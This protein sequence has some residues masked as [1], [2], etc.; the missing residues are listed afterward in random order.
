MHTDQT[1]LFDIEVLYAAEILFE[2][3]K[4][5]KD[6]EIFLILD[7]VSKFLK[8]TISKPILKN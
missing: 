6:L 7:L 3:Q 8:K 2:M 4:N 1:F 5:F